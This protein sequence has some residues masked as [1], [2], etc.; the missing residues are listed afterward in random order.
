MFIKVGLLYW[1]QK[2]YTQKRFLP[3]VVC[4]A[5][6]KNSRDAQKSFLWF[7]L[8]ALKRAHKHHVHM[9]VCKHAHA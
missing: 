8:Q 2:E 3:Q 9:S 4:S 5:S 1:N 6:I 7:I